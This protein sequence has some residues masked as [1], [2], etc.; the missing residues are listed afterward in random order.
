MN[1][2]AA[3]TP[4]KNAGPKSAHDFENKSQ[5][6]SVDDNSQFRQVAKKVRK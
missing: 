6:Q 4:T 2:K 5:R 1:V 3:N